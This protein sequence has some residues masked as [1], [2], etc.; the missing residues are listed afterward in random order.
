MGF[1][2]SSV[3]LDLA[4]WSRKTLTP[5]KSCKKSVNLL[6]NFGKLDQSVEIEQIFGNFETV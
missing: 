6:P 4:L 3:W 5:R 1:N 2:N